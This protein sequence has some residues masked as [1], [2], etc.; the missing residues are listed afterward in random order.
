M[1]ETLTQIAKRIDEHLDRFE[2]DITG[3]NKKCEK[4]GVYPYYRAS[5]YRAGNRVA[6]TYVSYQGSTT[7]KKDE[8]LEYLAWLDA[9]NVG[10]HYEQQRGKHEG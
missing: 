2:A 3:V 7:L 6:V 1:P 8:A 5:A 4:Y 9:G 10:R